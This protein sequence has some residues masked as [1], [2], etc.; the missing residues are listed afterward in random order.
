MRSPLESIP[1]APDDESSA[2]GSTK[3]REG[4]NEVEPETAPPSPLAFWAKLR[5]DGP[6][7][8][9]GSGRNSAAAR[10][11]IQRRE[12]GSRAQ[13]CLGWFGAAKKWRSVAPFGTAI[14][15]TRSSTRRSPSASSGRTRAS[16]NSKKK[17]SSRSGKRNGT[18]AKGKARASKREAEPA[19]VPLSRIYLRAG[20]VVAALVAA[21]V[22]Y[23]QGHTDDFA[24]LVPKSAAIS[25]KKSFR[26]GQVPKKICRQKPASMMSSMSSLIPVHGHIGGKE[27]IAKSLGELGLSKSSIQE[28]QAALGEVIDPSL[29][30][31][32]AY[33]LRI[34]QDTKLVVHGLEIELES[35]HLVQ[36]CREDGEFKARNLQ[37]RPSTKTGLLSLRLDAG[38][39]LASALR[40]AGENIELAHKLGDLLAAEMDP[41]TDLRPSDRIDLIV[42]KRFVGDTFHRYGRI[43]AFSFR[44][45]AG[46][47]RYFYRK[48][49][50]GNLA[51]YD[52]AGRPMKRRYLKSP[53]PWYWATAGGGHARPAEQVLRERRRGAEYRR[54]EGLPVFAM[55]DLSITHVGEDPKSGGF[56]ESVDA[57]GRMIRLSG[58]SYPL[59][60]FSRGD[61][62]KQGQTLGFVGAKLGQRDPRLRI[63]L[64]DKD[65]AWVYL[66]DFLSRGDQ[67]IADERL[68]ERLDPHALA[69]HRRA[70]SPWIKRLAKASRGSS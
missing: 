65:G 41:L 58:L 47:H 32:Q 18:K 4:A 29:L 42:E 11:K 49:S 24:K 48:T 21:N 10:E 13:R 50:Q 7:G 53:T 63:E 28:V 9:W 43:L 40:K 35:G 45:A 67:G 25:G 27:P 5:R 1:P 39:S 36:L 12:F 2:R 66:P 68:G 15:V 17:T 33:P 56:V 60:R 22:F 34:R 55:T 62:V 16:R 52:R 30:A 31:G 46:K 69:A 51:Y 44:G 19:G 6:L 14:D 59:P 70:I 54:P 23:F 38:A 61:E 37:L 8:W 57:D 64:R 26:F 3:S 20:A